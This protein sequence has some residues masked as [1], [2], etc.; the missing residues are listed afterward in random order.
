MHEAYKSDKA[1][2]KWLR[3]NSSG[4]Y[5]LAGYAAERIDTL[6]AHLDSL[7]DECDRLKALL[8]KN[9]DKSS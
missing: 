4:A 8:E 2:C 1:L 5:R 7:H 6:N 9:D 3:D